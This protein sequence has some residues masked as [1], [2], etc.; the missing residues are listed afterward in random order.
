MD[1][2]DLKR[3]LDALKDAEVK[4]FSLETADYKVSVKR[5][6]D[7]IYSSAPNPA[8]VIVT[9]PQ[10][11]LPQQAAVA[12]AVVVASSVND[13]PVA[14]ASGH[15]QKAPIVGTFYASS[16][17]DAAAFVQ[18]G[19]KV[20]AGKVICIIEA[21]KLMNEIEAEITGT[22]KE[23]LVKNAQPVEYGQPLFLIE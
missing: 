13:T 14:V 9:A 19:S 22:I 16:S 7:V 11:P 17:P 1:P 4:E 21:M 8:P 6:A 10:P 15:T 18:V 5:G 12:T 23:I 3:L 20:E 2:K